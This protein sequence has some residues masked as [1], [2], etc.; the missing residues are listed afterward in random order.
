MIR[1]VVPGACMARTKQTARKSTNGQAPRERLESKQQ[2]ALKR[3]E[4]FAE[5]ASV[6]VATPV[7]SEAPKE[8]KPANE[9]Q[10]SKAADIKIKLPA[11]SMKQKKTNTFERIREK[12]RRARLAQNKHS[13]FYYT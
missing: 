5:S 2:A 8:P 9:T 4:A 10:V 13:A 12:S 1:Q 6:P 7:A 11:S 3:A